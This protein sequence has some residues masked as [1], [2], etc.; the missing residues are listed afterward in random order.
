MITDIL[1]DIAAV[2]SLTLFMTM[3]AVLAIVIPE[4]L[5]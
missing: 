4:V 3:I 5:S 2:L 1:L